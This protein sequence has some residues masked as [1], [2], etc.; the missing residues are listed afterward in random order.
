[1]SA[2]D[3]SEAI[4]T[5]AAALRFIVHKGAGAC[6]KW[7]RAENPMHYF[8][9]GMDPDLDTALKDAAQETVEFL[10]HRAGLSA[11][12]AYAL[13]SLSADFRI[14]EA[15]NNV[16]MVYGMVPKNLFKRNPPYWYPT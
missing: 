5:A 11:S 9:L 10:Q 6:M 1:M 2:S 7:P 8:L 12:D 3:M 14:G 15:V 16:K 4:E 13:A